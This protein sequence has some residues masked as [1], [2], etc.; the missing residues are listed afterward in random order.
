M[1]HATVH[2]MSQEMEE[3]IRNCVECH[4]V[5]L[6]TVT[7]CLAQGGRHADDPQMK[8]CAEICRQCAASCAQMAK[9][10]VA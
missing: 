7:H 2:T 8:A 3:C 5:C 4:G 6:Q 1:P 9:R 10:Q